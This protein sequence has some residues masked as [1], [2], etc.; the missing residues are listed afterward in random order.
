MARDPAGASGAEN[1]LLGKAYQQ[2]FKDYFRAL[3][4]RRHIRQTSRRFQRAVVTG[5]ALIL[6]LLATISTLSVRPLLR[7]A[8]PERTVV[9]QWLRRETKEFDIIKWYPAELSADEEAITVRVQ[10]RYRTSRGR[11]IHTDRRFVVQGGDVVS[12]DSGW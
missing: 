11:T 5:Q 10:Y 12:V 2:V 7:R 6:L 9:E 3:I 4:F 1:S 8:P